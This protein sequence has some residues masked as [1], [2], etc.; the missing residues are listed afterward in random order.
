[1]PQVLASMLNEPRLS[2]WRDTLSPLPWCLTDTIAVDLESVVESA[3]FAKHARRWPLLFDPHGVALK[4]VCSAENYLT[5][6]RGSGEHSRV[7]R[8]VETAAPL[9]TSVL[10]K[11]VREEDLLNPAIMVEMIPRCLQLNTATYTETEKTG[12]GSGHVRRNL[13]IGPPNLSNVFDCQEGFRFYMTT[14]WLKRPLPE[15]IWDG[16]EQLVLID[17]AHSPSALQMEMLRVIVSQEQASL[18]KEGTNIVQQNKR[19]KERVSEVEK[20]V[21]SALTVQRGDGTSVLDDGQAIEKSRIL[22][23]EVRGLREQELDLSSNKRDLYCSHEHYIPVACAAQVFFS[24]ISDLIHVE[25]VYAF[26]LTWFVES[27]LLST[28]RGCSIGHAA[29]QADT[30]QNLSNRLDHVR[31]KLAHTLFSRVSSALLTKDR[32]LFA[33]LLAVRPHLAQGHIGDA[34]WHFLLTGATSVSWK[35]VSAPPD[36]GVTKTSQEHESKAPIAVTEHANP[37]KTWLPDEQWNEMCSLATLPTFAGLIEEFEAQIKM[38]KRIYDASEPHEQPLPR[39]W[40]ADLRGVN[41]LC[42]LRCLRPDQIANAVRRFVRNELGNN[43]LNAPPAS[44]DS[45]ISE[46]KPAVPIMVTTTRE[47]T[48]AAANMVIATGKHMDRFIAQILV[49]PGCRSSGDATLAQARSRGTWVLVRNP[50]LCP[51]F[52]LRLEEVCLG[53]AS[54]DTNTKFRLWFVVDIE[55]VLSTN[56]LRLATKFAYEPLCG[57]RAVVLDLYM[58]ALASTPDFLTRCTRGNEF[59]RLFF[60]LCICHAILRERIMYGSSAPGVPCNSKATCE[61]RLH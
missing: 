46:S 42:I 61:S 21:L 22:M 11:D 43:F 1:M 51:E 31:I 38:W 30:D 53:W 19:C 23:E 13:S 60:A 45:I 5:V 39:H 41:R 36:L 7:H 59:R 35:Q 25:A 14:Q 20:E 24:A 3:L 44:I 6:V 48:A 34:E 54:V 47:N 29:I 55:N 2:E 9:G 37:A 52:S 33:L 26:S 40:D 18:Y 12:D 49:V 17:F 28:L 50:Q 58:S 10:I 4:W 16:R 56:V 15:V 32:L 8:A 57:V 27:I